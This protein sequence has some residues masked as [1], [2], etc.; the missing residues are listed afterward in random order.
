MLNDK[1]KLQGDPE[2]PVEV[3]TRVVL[4]PPKQKAE[5]SIKPVEKPQD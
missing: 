5:V 1:M 2:A 3:R 4:V